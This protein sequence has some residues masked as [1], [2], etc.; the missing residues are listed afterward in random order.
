MATKKV[1]Q[2]KT[3]HEFSPEEMFD[4]N[5]AGLHKIVQ[6]KRILGLRVRYI[7]PGITQVPYMMAFLIEGFADLIMSQEQASKLDKNQ[8]FLRVMD[9]VLETTQNLE[10]DSPTRV[11]ESEQIL[12]SAFASKASINYLIPVLSQSYP[13]IDFT[14]CTN[15]C[16]IACFNSLFSDMFNTE[17]S[18]EDDEENKEN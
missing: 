9:F 8:I 10:S 15:E 18:E 6:P 3:Q 12:G 1:F 13:D 2:V 16:F 11:T 4:E 14:R 7:K 17:E 5:I